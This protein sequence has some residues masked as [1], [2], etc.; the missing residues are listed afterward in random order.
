MIAVVDYEAG[1]VRSVLH[2]L[3]RIGAGEVRLSA[4]PEILRSADKVILPG[5][6]DA[7]VALE[8]LRRSGLAEVLL[9]LT[10]P[11]L[12]ICVGMQVLCRHTEEGDVDGLGVFDAEVKRFIPDGIKV[13]HMGWNTVE[14]KGCALLEGLTDPVFAY[15]VHSFY[16]EISPDTAAISVHGIP[17]SAILQHGNFSGTQFHPEKSGPAGARILQ[18]F[19]S[20]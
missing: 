12:G 11:V 6:G 3:E 10:R 14:G 8:S 13:P 20:L 2:A 16:A 1:N 7:S 15:Y 9:S 17:F 19:L 4:D 18:N 5:V